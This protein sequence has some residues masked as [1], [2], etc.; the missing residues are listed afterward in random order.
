MSRSPKTSAAR[1]LPHS[2]HAQLNMYALAAGSAGVAFLAL[3]QPANAKVVY[4]AA[5]VP[6][7]GPLGHYS[8][9][10]NHDGIVDFGLAN[11]TNYNTDQQFWNLSAR[12][13]RGN[14]VA[15]TFVYRGFPVNAHAFSAGQEIGPPTKFFG[16]NAKL[17]SFYAGG[18]GY[19]AHGNWVGA[20]DRYLGVKFQIGGQTHYGWVRLNVRVLIRPVR[21]IALLTGYAYE[22]DPDT[23]I[24][25]GATSTDAALNPDTSIAPDRTAATLGMLAMGTPGLSIWRR[26]ESDAAIQ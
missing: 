2:V 23:P 8:I 11:T 21:I 15:G 22:T 4:T 3:T 14:S 1:S 12:G 17:A 16:G 19:S 9:D 18:G 6:I 13:V 24:T 25:A 20:T 10:L 5:H 7:L 26:R